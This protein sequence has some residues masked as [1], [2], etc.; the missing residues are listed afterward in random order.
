MQE[1]EFGGPCFSLD[2]IGPDGKLTRLCK[3]GQNRANQLALQQMQ[4]DAIE[5][6]KAR[7]FAAQQAQLQLQTARENTELARQDREENSK[8][9]D[10]LSNG[11]FSSTEYI[12]DRAM[13]RSAG[14]S[15][16][17]LS[18]TLRP[19]SEKRSSLG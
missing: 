4:M 5:S 6:E 14:R 17:G 1:C 3:G 12:D 2:L 11:A 16:F 7:N 19:Q 10:R 8:I 15:G 13:K 18:A 9:L